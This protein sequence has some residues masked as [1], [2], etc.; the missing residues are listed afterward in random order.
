M[1]NH[2]PGRRGTPTVS[3]N[4]VTASI[5]CSA[6][7]IHKMSRLKTV[8]QWWLARFPSSVGRSGG[9]RPL[10]RYFGAG[11]FDCSRRDGC[12]NPLRYLAQSGTQV[13]CETAWDDQI[14][15]L[16]KFAAETGLVDRVGGDTAL[17]QPRA[18]S[19]RQRSRILS[20]PRTTATHMELAMWD[21]YNPRS[22]SRCQTL[23]RCTAAQ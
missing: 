20:R 9:N 21:G 4:T 17:R 3:P 15:V 14:L 22:Q 13:K 8:P 10:R 12:F 16:P 11:L 2:T 18:A 7:T 1:K 6:T 19:L 5:I 23:H